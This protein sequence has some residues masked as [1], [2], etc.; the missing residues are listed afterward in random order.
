[1]HA[2]KREYGDFESVTN[3]QKTTKDGLLT[4][5]STGTSFHNDNKNL[6]QGAEREEVM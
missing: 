2:P 5:T 4:A 3:F 6:A 1:M